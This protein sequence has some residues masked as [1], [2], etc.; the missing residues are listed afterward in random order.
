M[1]AGEY[2]VLWGA[3]ALVM[4][5][6][7][8]AHAA[9]TEARSVAMPPETAA[10]LTNARRDGLLTREHAVQVDNAELV[11]GT[12]KLGL[13]SSAAQCVAALGA[14]LAAEGQPVE[15][16]REAVARAARRGHREAQGGGS[17]VDVLASALGGVLRVAFPAGPARE[18]V[19]ERLAW[20]AGLRWAVLWTGVPVR[21]SELILAVR[22][23]SRRETDE[24]MAAIAEATTELTAALRTGDPARAVEAV[25]AHGVAMDALG[26]A[27][28]VPIVTGTMRQLA[29]AAGPL[30]VA[31]KPSGAGGGDIVLAVAQD[32]D[33]LDAVARLGEPLGFARLDLAVD[34][35]GVRV[36]EGGTVQG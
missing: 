34:L 12:R 18:P 8:Y 21:T 5:V 17:G 3:D 33:A 11:Q 27:S 16:R 6:D 36:L 20:P 24:R 28:G 35:H 30:G 2:A 14:A 26:Q 1:L 10:A 7:R 31:V 25:R 19:V 22:A 23:L 13:G 9:V 32:A 15:P 29:A 4:A